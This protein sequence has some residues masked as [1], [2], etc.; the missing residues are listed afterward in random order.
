M[1]FNFHVPT[2]VR[3]GIGVVEDLGKTVAPY[4]K[5]ALLV[6]GGSSIKRNGVY[7]A[8]TKSLKEAG[9]EWFELPG[10]EPN[11]HMTTVDKGW[12]ICKE[13]G[14]DFIVAAGG[15]SSVDC[16]KG[17]AAA[18]A[19][20]CSV[21]TLMDNHTPVM[22]ALP[23]FVVLTLAATGSEM[24]SGGVITDTVKKIKGGV[25]GPALAPT[26]SFLD[27]SYT[28]TVPKRQTAAG[29]ADIYTHTIENYFD[30]AK[31]TYFVDGVAE[32]IL[33]TCVKYGPIAIADPENEEARSNLM[34][35]SP[36]AINGLIG[37]GR[38]EGW[39]LHGMQ[40]PIGAW[41]DITHGEG[42][43]I[44]MPHWMRRVLNEDTL[45]KF[46]QY[47][48]NVFGIDPNLDP[49]EIAEKAIECTEDFLFNK[50]GIPRT[51]SEIGVDDKHF[52]EMAT[53]AAGG[54]AHGFVPLT[55]EDVIEIYRK[56]L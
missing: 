32:S 51:L 11:P 27:P 13:N 46:V 2:A 39:S 55:K 25:F 15:G 6:Y 14:V 52:D 1:K 37:C 47:G 43:A 19:Y 5:K 56:A 54:L 40:H 36:W 26:V 28:Y 41:Y 4:G 29:T 8:V 35:A 9:I 20:D 34:W 53:D 22:K 7:D 18:T 24:D 45:F 49:H 16:A 3:F 50:L 44:L 48:V 33:R 10:V 31:D 42:L 17:V 38:N 21:V 23:L 30:T 12:Q